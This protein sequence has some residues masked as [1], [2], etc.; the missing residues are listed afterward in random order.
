MTEV[1]KKIKRVV[2][3]EEKWETDQAKNQTTVNLRNLQRPKGRE[4]KQFRVRTEYMF[5]TKRSLMLAQRTSRNVRM[6]CYFKFLT[7]HINV[8]K[9]MWTDVDICL[10]IVWL[11]PCRQIDVILYLHM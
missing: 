11:G 7:R 4:L 9:L 10:P 3:E 6:N 5:A 1:T 8:I 2:M